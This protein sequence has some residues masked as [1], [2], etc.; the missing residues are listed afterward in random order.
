[1]LE[2]YRSRSMQQDIT[3]TSSSMHQDT[4]NTCWP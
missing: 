4:P 3:V 1:M 2:V